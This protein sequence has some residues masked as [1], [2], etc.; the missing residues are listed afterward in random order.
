LINL[1]AR[2][3]LSVSQN[4]ELSRLIAY[5]MDRSGCHG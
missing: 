1:A 3:S 2:L 4:Y 5:R